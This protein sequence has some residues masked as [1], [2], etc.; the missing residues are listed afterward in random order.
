MIL[1][2]HIVE[3]FDVQDLDQPKPSMLQQQPVGVL[4][5]REARAA[6]V[7]DD[8][9]GPTTVLDRADKERAGSSLIADR[10]PLPWYVLRPLPGHG[11]QYPTVVLAEGNSRTGPRSG[12]D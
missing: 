3:I 10:Y 1:L 6:I 8:L 5:S 12:H 9:L 2:N 7:D 11:S 4:Q